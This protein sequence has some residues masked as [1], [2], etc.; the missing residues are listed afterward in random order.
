MGSAKQSVY[1]DECN[2]EGVIAKLTFGCNSTWF[3][4]GTVLQLGSFKSFSRFLMAKFETPMFFTF[5]L[6]GSFCNSVPVFSQ[7]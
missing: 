1:L 2:R 7:Q 6:S 4:A 3:T 5:P